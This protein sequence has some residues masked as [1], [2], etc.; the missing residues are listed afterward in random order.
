MFLQVS[1]RDVLFATVIAS[2]VVRENGSLKDKSFLTDRSILLSQHSTTSIFIRSL[3]FP[4][5]D[6]GLSHVFL[7]HAPY[8]KAT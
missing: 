8:S 1:F 3:D 2:I 7:M 4:D 6:Y 5:L